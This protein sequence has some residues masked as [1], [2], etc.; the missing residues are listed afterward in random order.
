MRSP[1]LYPSEPIFQLLRKA[2]TYFRTKEDDIL[3]SKILLPQLV[4]YFSKSAHNVT[5]VFPTCHDVVTKLLTTFFRSRI[6]LLLRKYNN[7]HPTK[8]SSKCGS[9]SVGMRV[10]VNTVTWN[11]SC[12]MYVAILFSWEHPRCELEWK[13]W[14]TF[15][16]FAPEGVK[17]SSGVHLFPKSALNPHKSILNPLKATLN[18]P[19]ILNPVYT[20]TQNC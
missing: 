18:P 6:H 8:Q 2:E 1:L 20:K 9:K 7:E 4:Q 16:V 10:A 13:L 19:K 5:G 14:L 15:I 3:C 12:N 11:K 17:T